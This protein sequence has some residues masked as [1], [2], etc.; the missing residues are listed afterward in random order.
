MIDESDPDDINDQ[1]NEASEEFRNEPPVET[2][3]ETEE[4]DAA[5]FEFA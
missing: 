4:E 5:D 3:Q 1:F 2:V